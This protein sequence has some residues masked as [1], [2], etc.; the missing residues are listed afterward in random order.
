MKKV[1]LL[2]V[3]GLLL[4]V[5]SSQVISAVGSAFGTMRTAQALGQGKANLGL[6]IGLGFD[7]PGDDISTYVGSFAFGLSEYSDG[8]IK[9]GLWDRGHWVGTKIALGADYMWQFWSKPKAP[10]YPA[11]LGVGGFLEYVD[12]GST[13]VLQLGGQLAFSTLLWDYDG[14]LLGTYGKFNTRLEMYN[15]ESNLET[16]FTAGVHTEISSTVNMYME[17]QFDG[18]DGIFMGI[19]INIR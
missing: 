8:R 16:G 14:G 17:A 6:G 2:S 9:L 1:I 15:S 19:D 10:T 18:N 13:S 5:P 12:F 4:V 7:D 3:V 11:Y